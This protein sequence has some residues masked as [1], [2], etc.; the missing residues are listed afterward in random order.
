[1]TILELREKRNKAWEAA[2][3]FLESHRTEKG[4]L[5][6][7]DDAT[8][9]QMEQEINDL[10]KE[11]ARLERQEALEA[12]L[13]RPVNQPLTSKPGSGRGEEPKTGRA[14]DEYRKAMLDAFRSNFKRVS[15]IL[16]EG[17]DADGGY[18]VPEE[19]DHRLI[20]TLSEE[21]IMRRL[22][23]IITTSGEHKINIAATKPAASWI[24]EGGALTF[25]DATFSQILLDAHKLHVAIKVTE[26]LLYDNAFNLEGYILDQ[27][28]KALANAE[29]DAFLN[30][31]GTGKPLGLFAATGGGTE[32]GTLSAAIKSDDMLDLVYALKRP[33]R[34]SASFI[35]NDKTLSSLR[36][37]KD[38][39][40]AY[41]WQ[42][43]Y[44]A[45]E[46]DRILGY[47]VH[48]SAYAPE[49]AIAFGDYKYYNI[50][51]RGTRS[52]SELRELF[53]GNGMIGYVAK[54]RVDGKLILP[55]A[56]QILKLKASTPSGAGTE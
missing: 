41:I 5:T 31:D 24:E 40:G 28:G 30:G 34:K 1:M 54:E 25:G 13:N 14:S 44:Q 39:N 16:Q 23:T 19:Y 55:E 22:A 36:K 2:K 11:I 3:A 37:L 49:D 38:N 6:A 47:A 20:D 51:D 56:V 21:N 29:E 10:G 43:S 9:T 7:E 18:L 35:L 12:E 15:N 46:P 26:E 50:G 17:V 33:Y 32:A 8:Y 48:T 45:G 4:T 53:A 42:P 52:F 27:F